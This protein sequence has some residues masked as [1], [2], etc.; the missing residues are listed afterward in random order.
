MNIAF[1]FNSDHESLGAMYGL[2]IMKKI[3]ETGVLQKANRHMR[4]SIGDVL[5]YPRVSAS[6]DRSL[7]HLLTL[8]QGLYRT[9][10]FDN[11]LQDRLDDTHGKATVYCWMFQNM[12]SEIGLQLH[13]SLLSNPFYLGAMDTIFADEDH[14]DLFRNSLIEAYRLNGTSCSIFYVMGDNDE[15]VSWIKETFTENG[16]SVYYEDTGARRTI[17]DNFDKV[18]HFRRIEDFKQ[19]F[20][21]LS[22][23]NAD[24]VSDITLN[25][26]E[27][28]PDLFNSL[29]SAARTIERAETE[30]D[31]AQAALS[32]R[33]FLE[34]IANYLFPPRDTPWKGREVG[35]DKYKNRLIAHIEITLQ[36]DP[37]KDS[38]FRE[39]GK[40]T[41]RL[42]ELFNDG[43][44]ASPSAS[45]VKDALGDLII[46]VSRVI[47]LSPL[48]ARKPYL[49]YIGPINEILT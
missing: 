46:W 45:K 28:H 25:L 16:F 4:V 12:T 35:A 40:E 34:K 9:T 30:E 22:G 31:Y 49:A 18:D 15:P 47:A 13:L 21:N 42:I 2:S 39:L 10:N 48:S 20:A 3:M 29:A 7:L 8:C 37:N 41:N 19:T 14:L 5:T 17:F 44:H 27:L 33:R 32:G 11:L 43:L 24:I 6:N 38:L 36:S 23:L 26:E 1:L